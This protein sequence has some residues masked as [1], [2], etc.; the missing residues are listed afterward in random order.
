MNI[1]MKIKSKKESVDGKNYYTSKIIE[2]FDTYDM[3]VVLKK[4]HFYFIYCSTTHTILTIKYK[5]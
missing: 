5:K 3:C 2:S 1:K 4:F